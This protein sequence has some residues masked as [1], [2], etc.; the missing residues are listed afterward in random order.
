MSE[1]KFPLG[2]PSF[3]AF[4]AER[5]FGFL[6]GSLLLTIGGGQLLA[7]IKMSWGIH[8]LI[9]INLLVL[10]SVVK[11]R[12]YLW[13]GLAFFALSL[14]SWSLSTVSHLKFLAP[15]EQV[16]AVALLIMGTTA[17]F[18][19]AFASGRQ[20]DKERIFAS[21]SLYLM[22]GLIFALLFGLVDRLLPGSFQF[23]STVPGDPGEKPLTQLIYFSYVTLATL[24]Y[25]DI[26][27]LTGPAK[28]LAILEAMIGQLYLVLVV[29]RLVS[30]YGQS[31]SP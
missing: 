14:I 10:L 26:V 6:F 20:V 27:P 29:A 22:F 15:G 12:G 21:L 7:E 1:K 8:S 13:A 19:A 17:C 25:G 4:L 18:R 9:A 31:E 23:P 5:R 2:L 16:G 30:L 28:G 3:I 24:G 11:D